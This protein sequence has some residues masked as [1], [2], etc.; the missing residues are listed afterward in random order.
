[1]FPDKVSQTPSGSDHL[2]LIPTATTE[3][4]SLFL[5]SGIIKGPPNQPP[6]VHP[7]SLH[8]SHSSSGPLN[9]DSNP[10][11]NP[12]NMSPHPQNLISPCHSLGGC[13]SGCLSDYHPRPCTPAHQPQ[14]CF[15]SI[16]S[17]LP[18]QDLCT[19][20]SHCWELFPNPW[21][22]QGSYPSSGFCSH[23]IL[24]EAFQPC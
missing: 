15:Q 21:Y 3:S 6:H 17:S 20:S 7:F 14:G 2:S 22:Q 19:H 16:P 1:M 10:N 18:P 4:R 23:V 12:L 24:S 9:A 11:Q 5:S 13:V 8:T